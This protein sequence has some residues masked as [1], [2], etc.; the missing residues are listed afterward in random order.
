LKKENLT[1]EEYGKTYAALKLL[2]HLTKIG[3]LKAHIFRKVLNDYANRIDI[4]DFVCY[5]V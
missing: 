4:S 2:E 5:N 1:K 3:K